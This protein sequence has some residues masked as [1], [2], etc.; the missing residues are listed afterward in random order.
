MD[1][2]QRIIVGSLGV[3][4]VLAGIG[5]LVAGTLAAGVPLVAVG[6]MIGAL[7]FGRRHRPVTEPAVALVGKGPMVIA[8]ELV[9]NGI[10]AHTVTQA[11]PDKRKDLRGG[12]CSASCKRDNGSQVFRDLHDYW[13]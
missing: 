9:N 10:I 5:F 12:S 6:A 13:L 7:G 3:G 11:V 8:R 4:M 2:T 1:D